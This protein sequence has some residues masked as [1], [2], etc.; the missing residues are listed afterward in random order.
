VR[1]EIY[2]QIDRHTF[3]ELEE[4]IY[5]TLFKYNVRKK[6]E[7]LLQ[8]FESEKNNLIYVDETEARE[9]FETHKRVVKLYLDNYF[10]KTYD[11]ENTKE[12]LSM[13]LTLYQ[14]EFETFN[15]LF[16]FRTNSLLAL[17][18]SHFDEVEEL[19]DFLKGEFQKREI[20]FDL[21]FASLDSLK[22]FSYLVSE[23]EIKDYLAT[24]ENKIFHD[25][26][27]LKIKK[28]VNL[29]LYNIDFLHERYV[30]FQI[31]KKE[32]GV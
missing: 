13:L 21:S 18:N 15:H 29:S 3:K 9:C 1:E 19:Q 2:K 32:L 23:I 22:E 27:T 6:Q 11:I 17:A 24:I 10:F 4:Y 28:D 7:R 8:V 14:Y 31:V 5:S 25:L 26:E 12:I 20:T 30:E 16:T